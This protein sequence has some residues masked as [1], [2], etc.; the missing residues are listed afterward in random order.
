MLNLRSVRSR[1]N[2]C[3]T[4]VR[5]RSRPSTAQYHPRA[6]DHI[7]LVAL[8]PTVL[9]ISRRL[10]G[11]YV[12]LNQQNGIINPPNAQHYNQAAFHRDLP[13]QHFVS[14]HP[15]RSMP[16]FA[17]IPLRRR[18]ARPMWC[19]PVTKMR[20]FHPMQP[21]RPYRF[22][23]RA[24]A[25]SF[26]ILDC[27]LFHCGGI[28]R[29]DRV[30]RAVNHVYSIP[31]IRQQIDLPNLLGNDYTSDPRLAVAR[32]RRSHSDRCCRLLCRTARS[33]AG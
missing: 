14:S 20:P 17:S 25:G 30:R 13:Y 27:M 26:I 33:A 8:N 1:G 31:I 4:A 3:A 15:R 2:L 21:S 24:P 6:G 12:T 5:K 28:N 23:I 7:F 18:T 22:K 11:D 19:R 10:M 32:L 9:A 29:H 16:C